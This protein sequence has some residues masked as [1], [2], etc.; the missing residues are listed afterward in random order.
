MDYLATDYSD[1][2]VDFHVAIGTEIQSAGP[3]IVKPKQ[4]ACFIPLKELEKFI[5]KW[6]VISNEAGPQTG[7]AKC[8]LR[9]LVRLEVP[10][11]SE[12]P[13]R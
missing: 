1:A 13:P 8:V 6:N 7:K 12:A 2:K 9:K 11:R 3:H 10:C 4:G 5:G